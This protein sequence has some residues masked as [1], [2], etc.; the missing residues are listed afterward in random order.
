M[1]SGLAGE[2]VPV[3]CQHHRDAACGHQVPHAVHARTLEADATLAGVGYL[4]EDLVSFLSGVVP[5]SLELL[6]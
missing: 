4:L 6:C 2:A 1:V 5:E 3:L